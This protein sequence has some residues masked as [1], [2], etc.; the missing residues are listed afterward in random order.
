MQ[1]AWTDGALSFSGGPSAGVS[2]GRNLWISAGYNVAGYR[3]RDFEAD[4]YTRS[5]PYVT[6]R[7]KFDQQTIGTAAQALLG[8][9]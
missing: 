6:M 3:D 9:K 7:F 4:R 2:P 8:R 1:H 5:G